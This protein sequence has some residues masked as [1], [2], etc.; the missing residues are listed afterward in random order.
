MNINNKRELIDNIDDE[1]VALLRRRAELAREISIA[2]M[3]AGLPVQDIDRE[4]QVF[5][6]VRRLA[7][8]AIDPEA[9]D[10]IYVSIL[11]ESRRVQA[12]EQEKIIAG[13]VA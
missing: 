8:D 11:A 7:A 9:I 13:G 3:K 6:R 1:I 12:A 2:K 5:K 4:R 10:S